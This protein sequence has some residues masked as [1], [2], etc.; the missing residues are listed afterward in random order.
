MQ[1]L[2]IFFIRINILKKTR[3]TKGTKRPNYQTL[4]TFA[5]GVVEIS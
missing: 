2:T 1:N 5:N 3:I 4:E